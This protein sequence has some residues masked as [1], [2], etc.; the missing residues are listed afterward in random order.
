M[1]S[2][3]L[4]DVVDVLSDVVA[5]VSK[6]PSSATRRTGEKLSKS[7]LAVFFVRSI[8]PSTTGMYSQTPALVRCN[9]PRPVVLAVSPGISRVT[10]YFPLTFCGSPTFSRSK[11]SVSI[12]LPS[13]FCLTSSLTPSKDAI[14]SRNFSLEIAPEFTC[15]ISAVTSGTISF[16]AMKLGADAIFL[17]VS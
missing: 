17:V 8:L 12:S 6:V 14:S 15:S 1:L 9:N 4:S 11:T 7:K 13:T 5:V 16:R 3:F 2:V 10:R